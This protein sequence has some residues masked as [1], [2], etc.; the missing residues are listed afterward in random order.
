MAT[1]KPTYDEL[2]LEIE[3]LKK[4]LADKKDIEKELAKT[5]I[6]MQAAFDQSPVPLTVVTYPDFTFRIIN[7]ATED[8]LLADASHYLNKVPTEVDWTWKEFY[9]NGIPVAS[10]QDLPLPMAMQGVTTRNQEMYIV[11]HDGS[12]VWE[13]ASASPIYDVEGQLIGGIL[14]ITD[15]TERKKTEQIISANEKKLKEQNEEYEAINEEL[16]E[17]NEQLQI[18]KNKAEESDRLKTAFIQNMSHEIRTPMNAIMGFSDLLVDNFNDKTKLEKFTKIISLRCEDLLSIINDILDISKIESGQLTIDAENCDVKSLFDELYTF[19]TE[20]QKRTGKDE[21]NLKFDHINNETNF[22]F[23]TDKVKLKQILINLIGNAFK[24]TEKGSVTCGCIVENNRL[25]FHVSDTG[26]GIPADKHEY[27]FER[28]SQLHQLPQRNLGGTGLG[29]S[30]VRG[31]TGLLGGNVWLKSD[32]G[33]GT[34]FYFS[35]QYEKSKVGLVDNRVGKTSLL[36]ENSNKTILIVEDDYYNSEYLKE[37][38]SSFGFN[39]L[40]TELGK[41][42]IMIALNKP[43]DLILMDIRLPDITGY[44]AGKAIL[45]SKPDVKI[46]AQTAYAAI[47]EREK[48]MQNG[49]VDYI[50][51]PTKRD[52]LVSLINKHL[53]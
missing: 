32:P 8:F 49:C 10:I 39:I 25:V 31:L 29:L 9:P 24:F 50:S 46:I 3:N 48:A 13:L 43:I 1:G 42:A 33:K 22:S 17:A 37:I 4:Q 51:K 21:V 47:D 45:Q 28:F 26:I 20:Y 30:I 35:I 18:A 40:H 36:A 44:D 23:K 5:R 2:L 38:F 41:E 14:A 12:I 27:I 53:V 11:R 16:R 15:I 52:F 7:K 19:F 6:L 34:T